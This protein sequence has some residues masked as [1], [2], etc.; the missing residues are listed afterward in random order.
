M[1]NPTHH[2]TSPATLCALLLSIGAVAF[3]QSAKEET[4]ALPQFT[5]TEKPTGRYQSG[6]ALSASRVRVQLLVP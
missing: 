6:Q 2:T 3:A 4:V 1:K 5:L